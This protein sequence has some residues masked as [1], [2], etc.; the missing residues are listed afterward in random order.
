MEAS[1]ESIKVLKISVKVQ[2]VGITF[3]ECFKIIFTKE[4]WIVNTISTVKILLN[5]F[6]YLY[7]CNVFLVCFE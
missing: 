4:N 5:V 1:F 2:V 6:L 3:M 7:F